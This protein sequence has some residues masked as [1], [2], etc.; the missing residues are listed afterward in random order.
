L[1]DLTWNDP[2][3]SKPCEEVPAPEF[4]DLLDNLEI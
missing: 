3:D 1:G 2:S 4:S